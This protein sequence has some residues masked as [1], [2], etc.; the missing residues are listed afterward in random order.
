MAVWLNALIGQFLMPDQSHRFPIP[1]ERAGQATTRNANLKTAKITNLLHGIVGGPHQSLPLPSAEG[2]ICREKRE[3]HTPPF[4][5]VKNARVYSRIEKIPP[6]F[7]PPEV[8]QSRLLGLIEKAVLRVQSNDAPVCQCVSV[9]GNDVF[10]Q[11]LLLDLIWQAA[12]IIE[13]NIME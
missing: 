1:R 8:N 11:K 10:F 3:S 9:V 6:D 4:K 7:I 2:S 12:P 13:E 5:R